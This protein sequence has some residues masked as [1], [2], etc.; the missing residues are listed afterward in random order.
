[1]SR[2]KLKICGVKE[3]ETLALLQ[4]Y[5]VDYVGFVIAPSKRNVSLEQVR[6]LLQHVPA[7]LKTVGVV[8]D[9]QERLSEIMRLG[10]DVIQ[11][12]GSESPEDCLQ[13]RQTGCSVWKAFSLDAG[14]IVESEERVRRLLQKIGPYQQCIDAVLLDTKVKGQFGGTGKTFDWS[15]IPHV[16]Q[17]LIKI[18]LSLYV[19]G[20]VNADNVADLLDYGPDGVD[21]SSGVETDGRKDASKI[22]RFI[23]QIAVAR[24]K[25][26][27][28]QHA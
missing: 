24:K 7:P 1:M 13:I 14:E 12:H 19:A 20:G 18:G 6:Q 2:P 9:E 28:E 5:Q 3:R 25:R 11:C 4:A 17:E 10:L 8:V 26:R 21:V 22:K 23:E 27:D 16:R 15:V